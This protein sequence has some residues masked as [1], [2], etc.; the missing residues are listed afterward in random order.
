MV[1]YSLKIIIGNVIYYFIF[2]FKES[3]TKKLKDSK[4]RLQDNTRKQKASWLCTGKQREH[5]GKKTR[6]IRE[7]KRLTKS[8]RNRTRITKTS[9]WASQCKFPISME[10]M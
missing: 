8:N 2:F 10:N 4:K 3:S 6:K 9:L 5:K 1:F 7:K